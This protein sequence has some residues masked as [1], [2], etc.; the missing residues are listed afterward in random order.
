VPTK[1]HDALKWA[2]FVV[3]LVKDKGAP[4]LLPD[5]SNMTLRAVLFAQ[6]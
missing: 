3:F 1:T 6:T 2:K 4:V 5:K